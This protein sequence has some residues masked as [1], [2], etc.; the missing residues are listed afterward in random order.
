M[1]STCQSIHNTIVLNSKGYLLIKVPQL[2]QQGA[3]VNQKYYS[4]LII[5]FS[6]TKTQLDQLILHLELEMLYQLD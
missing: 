4:N 3:L 6:L 5:L 1:S 2:N